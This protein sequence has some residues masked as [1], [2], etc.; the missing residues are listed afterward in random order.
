MSTLVTLETDALIEEALAFMYRVQ[1]RPRQIALTAA[2]TDADATTFT[3]ASGDSSTLPATTVVEI[4]SELMLVTGES[5]GT[6]TVSRGYADTTAATHPIT[7]PVLVSPQ[8]SRREILRRIVQF[9][10]GPANLFL[11]RY[12]TATLSPASDAVSYVALP[13]DVVRVTEVRYYSPSAGRIVHIGNWEMH[14]DL[15]IDDFPSGKVLMLSTSVSNAD[16]V[17]VT[18]TV[19]HYFLDAS[20]D[21]IAVSAV[22]E[23]SKIQVT[24]GVETLPALYAAACLI[25][26]REIARLEVDT[27]EEWNQ[28]E[29]IRSGVPVRYINQLWQQF[30]RGVDEARRV[31]YRPRHRPYRKMPTMGV[32]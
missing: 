30:Y 3:V 2:I 32:R 28:E 22:D 18:Y 12:E 26:G 19:P 5:S 29:A 8:F 27:I 1:E 6:I 24:F 10:T 23:T 11:P 13:S 20:D 16:E 25:T 31:Q 14:E 7:S 9:F 17:L 15:P 21:Q 4:D